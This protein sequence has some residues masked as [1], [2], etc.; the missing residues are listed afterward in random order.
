MKL[1]LEL[2][3]EP[4]FGP[5]TMASG[6]RYR[7]WKGT[8]DSGVVVEAL[9]THIVPLPNQDESS[10]E[11]LALY[12]DDWQHAFQNQEVLYTADCSAEKTTRV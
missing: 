6:I 3:R 4:A 9:I 5:F 11:E 1:T 8:T 10:L 2:K 12:P 7:I